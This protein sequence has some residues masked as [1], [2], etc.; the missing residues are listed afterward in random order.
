VPRI[1]DEKKLFDTEL[2]QPEEEDKEEKE[3]PEE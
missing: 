2:K 3:K 1:S